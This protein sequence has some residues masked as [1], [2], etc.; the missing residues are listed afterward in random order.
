MTLAGL[1]RVSNTVR[2]LRL[3]TDVL[4]L[5]TH[6]AE[7]QFCLVGANQ[8]CYFLS[9]S[10]W[11]ELRRNQLFIPTANFASVQKGITYTSIKIHNSLLSNIL[12]FKKDRKL[13]KNELYRYLLNNSFYSVEE[14][15]EFGT[16]K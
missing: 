10:E 15:L 6:C 1:A 11:S 9:C 5:N 3:A 7:M 13:F 16:Y 2:C 14:F 8:C 4:H 12:S